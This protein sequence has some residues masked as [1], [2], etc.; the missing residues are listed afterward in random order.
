MRIDDF[1]TSNGEWCDP[2]GRKK[3]E[4]EKKIQ[5]SYGIWKMMRIAGGEELRICNLAL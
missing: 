2:T 3:K 5:R 4:G 1:S